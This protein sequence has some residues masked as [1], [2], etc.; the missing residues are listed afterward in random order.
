MAYT[1]SDTGSRGRGSS[2]HELGRRRDETGSARPHDHQN[3]PWDTNDSISGR[4]NQLALT[5]MRSGNSSTTGRRSEYDSPRTRSPSRGARIRFED[6]LDGLHEA[7]RRDRR[8]YD[9]QLVEL[10]P[11][12][13]EKDTAGRVLQP[14]HININIDIGREDVQN[15]PTDLSPP[16]I[17]S[18][19]VVRASYDRSRMEVPLDQGA[20]LTNQP[21]DEVVDMEFERLMVK[22]GW[23]ELS[24]YARS[25][26]ERYS[27][28]KK[29][30][31]ICEK[32]RQT[33]VQR[34]FVQ[35]GEG[36]VPREPH[37]SSVDSGVR[38]SPQ[39]E[40]Y[41]R[42]VQYRYPTDY[43]RTP[44]ALHYCADISN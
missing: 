17:P 27:A 13:D 2:P 11:H 38:Y 25:Y 42:T 31:L 4:R 15:L 7:I 23:D 32:S 14:R 22:Q 34:P 20:M 16:P 10:W 44:M 26:M 28:E 6:E 29:W 36:V 43:V 35:Y 1:L 30:M 40:H 24:V 12:G 39:L 19:R 5:R 33:G 9:R 3:F 8:P 37:R 18:Q 21:P 41:G